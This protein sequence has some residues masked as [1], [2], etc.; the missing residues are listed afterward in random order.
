[1]PPPLTSG[2]GGHPGGGQQARLGE[3][4][5]VGEPGGLAGDDADARAAVATGGELLDLAV[6]ETDAGAA[7]VGG[8]D[9]GEVSAGG[10]CGGEDPR[11]NLIV[12]QFH[13]PTLIATICRFKYTSRV[14]K[15][16]KCRILV[17]GW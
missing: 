2:L 15:A 5:G 8:E 7:P 16:T 6:V 3:V 13:P 12:Q 10:E 9:L 17:A 1:M 11:E 14:H 4:G